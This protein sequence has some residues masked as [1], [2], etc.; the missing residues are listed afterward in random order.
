LSFNKDFIYT[1]IQVNWPLSGPFF[2][3][4]LAS[5]CQF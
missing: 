3:I 1:V 5:V 2:A 4:T